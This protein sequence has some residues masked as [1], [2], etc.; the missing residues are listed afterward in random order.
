MKTP[1]L[2]ITLCITLLISLTITMTY[3]GTVVCSGTVKSI[4]YHSPDRVYVRLSSMN[5][6]VNI[7]RTNSTHSVSGTSYTT[8][9][10]TCQYFVSVLLAAK[11]SGK[12]ITNMY[13]DGDQVPSSCNSWES[14][15]QANVRH[16]Q[17][18]D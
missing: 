2:F 12:Q 5:T 1:K 14:W 18:R 11:L 8:A 13:F 3:A 7:C 4:S 15:R 17:F 6:I 9:P 10:E 16:F